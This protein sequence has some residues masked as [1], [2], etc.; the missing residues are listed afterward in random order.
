MEE[1]DTE[2]IQE[3]IKTNQELA[4]LWKEHQE[5]EDQLEDMNRRLFLTPEEEMQRKQLQKQK[6]IGRDRIEIILAEH[7]TA[8]DKD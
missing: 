3:L 2:L 5:F 7:R 8:Q 6:L 1:H 4:A